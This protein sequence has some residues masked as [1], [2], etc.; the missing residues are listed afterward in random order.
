MG[1]ITVLKDVS[2]SNGAK[3]Q[4]ES[5]IDDG[6]RALFDFRSKWSG[7]DGSVKYRSQIK[8]LTYNNATLTSEL[9]IPFVN[10]GI[11]FTVNSQIL[12][13][14]EDAIPVFDDKEWVLQFWFNPEQ[15]IQPNNINNQIINIS[16][17]LTWSWPS[18]I[19]TINL[20]MS[21]DIKVPAAINFAVRGKLIRLTDSATITKF[22][23]SATRKPI[24]VS[25]YYKY[26]ASRDL[27]EIYTD[28]TL[29]TS[30][31]TAPVVAEIT[32]PIHRF[33][34][35]STGYPKPVKAKF[36]RYRIDDLTK[37]GRTAKE[38]ISIEYEQCKNI[39]I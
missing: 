39:F 15:Y 33:L 1:L 22:T 23:A 30:L 2:L 4:R 16:N 36:Y 9:A 32:T 34:N 21:S 20:E 25:V 17:N 14:S 18:A 6:T 12:A 38:L 8:A 28:A 11:Y 24:L 27:I 5:T 10:T 35:A 7:V 29:L 31:E 13:I 26:R 19:C 37:T 3:L